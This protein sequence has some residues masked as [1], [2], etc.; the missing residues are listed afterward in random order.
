MT[1]TEKMLKVHFSLFRFHRQA[2]PQF[3]ARKYALNY[4][5]LDWV[6]KEYDSNAP[7]EQLPVSSNFQILLLREIAK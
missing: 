7:D 5:R 1:E 6:K 4:E 2:H 3:S